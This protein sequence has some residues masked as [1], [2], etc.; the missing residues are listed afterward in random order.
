MQENKR[1]WHEIDIIRGFA[2][3]LML[4]NHLAVSLFVLDTDVS[5]VVNIVSFWGSFAPVVFF[6]VTG[7]GYGVSAVPGHKKPYVPVLRKFL[8][9]LGADFFL[10]LRWTPRM[11]GWDFLAFIGMS[12]LFLQFIRNRK[13]PVLWS[14]L[15][16]ATLLLVRYAAGTMFKGTGNIFLESIL[17]LRE[18]GDISYWFTPWLVYPLIGFIAGS[19]AKKKSEWINDNSF[20]VAAASFLTAAPIAAFSIFLRTKGYGYFRWGIMSV[21]FFILSIVCVLVVTGAAVLV[22]R[23]FSGKNIIGAVSLRGVSSLVVVP[24][25]YFILDAAHLAS[26]ETV[27]ASYYYVLFPFL[28]VLSFFLAK[29][30]DRHAKQLSARYAGRALAVIL[31]SLTGLCL[32]FGILFIG[33]PGTVFAAFAGMMLLCYILAFEYSARV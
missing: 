24:I 2:V 23:V 27:P 26:V 11:L 28:V 25:H 7:I 20:L 17:G 9:L 31:I 29:T 32:I 22:G 19:I 18:I 6:F 13:R 16:I 33:T 10:R 15:F 14:S 3:I 8:I 21:N 1:Y 12:M 5:H 30:A 4:A